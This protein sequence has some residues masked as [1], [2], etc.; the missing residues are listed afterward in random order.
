MELDLYPGA[1]AELETR[2]LALKNRAQS[3]KDKLDAIK[4]QFISEI[5]SAVKEDGKKMFS[6]AEAREIELANRL[7]EDEEYLSF[8]KQLSDI[9]TEKA[10][11]EIALERVK[12]EFSVERYKLRLRT[13]E[14]VEQ[15]S[16]HFAEG[17][18]IV[19][20]LG[21][22]FQQLTQQTPSARTI[23]DDFDEIEFI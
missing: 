9:E 2:G 23:V 8:L 19:A 7:K 12:G 14:Q 21:N 11:N 3:L 13:A 22:L 6:N 1:I 20:G 18:Q 15:A 4:N 17:L 5:A 10:E 16:K